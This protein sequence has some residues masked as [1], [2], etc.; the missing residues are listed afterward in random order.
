MKTEILKKK[1]GDDN[2][3]VF[4]GKKGVMAYVLAVITQFNKSS[5]REVVLKARGMSISTAVDVAEIVKR[6]FMADA[7][8]NDIKIGTEEVE[9]REVDE[10]T[11]Q[12]RIMKVSSIEITL[13]R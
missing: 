10:K 11:G 2:N 9:S 12:P 13:R 1:R 7:K 4:I 3:V 6:R 8:V 5:A